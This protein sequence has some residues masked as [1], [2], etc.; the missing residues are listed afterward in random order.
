MII[1]HLRVQNFGIYAGEQSFN[2]QPEY[3]GRYHQPIILLRGQNGVGKSTI[4][5]AIRLALHG[6]LSLGN[7]TMQKEYES[8]LAQRLHRN[9]AGETAVTA[10]VELAFD[11]VFLGQRHQYRVR[12]Q[13]SHAN[14][15]LAAELQLWID[16]APSAESEEETEYLLRELAPPGVAELFFFDGEKVTTLAEAGDASDALLA[17]TV[18]NLLGLHLVEQLDRDLDIYLT[19]QTGIQELQQ[20][21]AELTR[22]HED[23]AEWEQQYDR[24]HDMLVDCRHRLSAKR[25]EIVLLEGRIAREGGQYAA[26]ETERN[27]ERQAILTGLAQSQQ[28]IEE[29]CRGVFPFAVAPNLLTA[30]RQRLEQEVAYEQWENAQP[31]LGKLEALVIKEQPASYHTKQTAVAEAG[32]SN[33]LDSIQQIIEEGKKPPIPETAIVH[34]IS[35][36]TRGVLFNWIDEALAASPQQMADALQRRTALKAQLA[37]VEESLKRVPTHQILQPLQDELRQLDRELGRLE[38]ELERLQVEEKRLGFQIERLASSKRK[39]SE[40]I[41]GINTDE[42]RIQLAART[43]LLLG[44]YQQQ[45]IN[46][47]LQQFAIQLV[48][49]FNQLSR[50]RN[51]IDQVAIDPRTFTITLYRAGQVFPRVQLSAGEEQVFAVATLWALREVSQRPLPVIIDT[52]LSRLDDEHRRTML[53]EFMPQVAQ[54]VIVLATNIE[55]D[56]ATARFLQP[57]VAREYRL[58]SDGLTTQVTEQTVGQTHSLIRLAEVAA[59]AM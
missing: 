48:K 49:R 21:Q 34:R 29:L 15:R 42:G 32:G 14:G 18:K 19:R 31:T 56:D 46:Q 43:Q 5:E 50:K 25:E 37:A 20:Y 4:M 9:I 44:N 27:E 45:L 35:A 17:E 53:A 7:R 33:L 58:Q 55:I 41:A 52:P 26:E 23:T 54:Q 10:A 59:H 47:K 8:Y 6:K 51:F 11:H 28:E 24:N 2:L 16:D 13:W 38:A 30:V 39:V 3:N 1:Q 40:K 36:E 12:R 22:L 57:V